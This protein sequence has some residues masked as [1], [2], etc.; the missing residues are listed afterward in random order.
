MYISFDEFPETDLS[1]EREACFAAGSNA[2]KLPAYITTA[3]AEHASNVNALRQT[4]ALFADNAP[5]R[6]LHGLVT[7]RLEQERKWVKHY[8]ACTAEHKKGTQVAELKAKLENQRKEAIKK[9]RSMREDHETALNTLRKTVRE[10]ARKEFEAELKA[11]KKAKKQA[12]KPWYD[13]FTRLFS[14]KTDKEGKPVPAPANTMKAAKPISEMNKQE[15]KLYLA[16]KLEENR[17]KQAA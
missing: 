13:W 4:V 12:K 3:R 6:R 17:K 7:K 1:K 5:K 14:A 11:K 9:E 2:E 8:D 10:E 16:K 15:R